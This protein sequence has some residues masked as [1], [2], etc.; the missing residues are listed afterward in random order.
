[1]GEWLWVVLLLVGYFVLMR[2]LLPLF[3]VPT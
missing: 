2:W 1:M 3:G